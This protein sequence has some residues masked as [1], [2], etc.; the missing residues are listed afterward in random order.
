MMIKVIAG[1][2]TGLRC[3]LTMWECE[4]ITKFWREVPHAIY[5]MLDINLPLHPK[6]FILGISP[7]YPIVQNK[8]KAQINICLLNAKRLIA[9][10]WKNVNKPHLGQWLREMSSC[11]SMEKI[12]YILKG[13][14]ETFD[15]IWE[16]FILFME[17]MDMSEAPKRAE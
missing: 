13:R 14:R 4:K 5:D 1:E 6:L 16:P 10:S 17:N 9:L 15:S 11:L 3:R 7:N 2:F 12:T 8:K